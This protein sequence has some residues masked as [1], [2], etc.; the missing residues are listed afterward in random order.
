MSRSDLPRRSFLAIAAG[1]MLA[2]A[3]AARAQSLG[4]ARAS[5]YLGERPD[6][7]L[8]PRDPSAPGWA[9]DPMADVNGRRRAR[10]EEP[11]DKNGASL[12]A[13]EIVAGEKI[14][15]SLPAGGYYMDAS[16]D[17]VQK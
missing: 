6:G 17:W 13:V 4:E 14:I 1:A 16:G 11:A 15:Q 9:L 8:A 12:R 2:S 3:G 10:Y 5:G 7:Y